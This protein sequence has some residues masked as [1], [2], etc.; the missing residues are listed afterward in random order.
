MRRRR[1]AGGER[2][3]GAAARRVGSVQPAAGWRGAGCGVG[4]APRQSLRTRGTGG[5]APQPPTVACLGE[6]GVVRGRSQTRAAW[7]AGGAE[8]E[9]RRV[10]GLSV[11]GA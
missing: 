3:G 5:A 10:T 1:G 11:W 6:P 7:G 4:G 8:R 9:A 2:A